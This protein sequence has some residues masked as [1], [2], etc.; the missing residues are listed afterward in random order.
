VTASV[1]LWSEFLAADPE[2]SDSIL[3]T[4]RFSEQQWEWNGVQ[5][6]LV[7]TNEDLLERKVVAL[8]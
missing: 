5:S 2:V 4:A 7:R 8:V 1:V 3:G 6:A